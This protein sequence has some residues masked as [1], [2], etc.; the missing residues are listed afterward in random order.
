MRKVLNTLAR[1]GAVVVLGVSLAA[2]GGGPAPSPTPPA[3]ST[4]TPPPVVQPTPDDGQVC[5]TS[6]VSVTYKDGSTETFTAN[7]L[8]HEVLTNRY[9][10]LIKRFD[11]DGTLTSSISF[12]VIY[13]DDGTF[14]SSGS[15]L[16]FSSSGFPVSTSLTVTSI[17][18]LNTC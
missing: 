9:N 17:N 7:L 2:C 14:R 16:E 6:I 12:T 8:R 3:P 4:S 11:A 15:K 1:L 5:V 18:R 13:N 10:T